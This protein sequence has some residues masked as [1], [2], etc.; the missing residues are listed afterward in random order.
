MDTAVGAWGAFPSA[1]HKKPGWHIAEP[2]IIKCNKQWGLGRM[3]GELPTI[4]L[5]LADEPGHITV[6]GQLLEVNRPHPFAFL[7]HPFFVITVDI[8]IRF[9]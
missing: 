1:S 3:L 5:L 2:G 7:C 4:F 6:S 9:A 8:I